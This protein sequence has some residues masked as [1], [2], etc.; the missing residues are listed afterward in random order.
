MV[1][2]TAIVGVISVFGSGFLIVAV[3]MW[4]EYRKNVLRSQE[5]LAAIEKGILP[6]AIQE[7]PDV[8]N[9]CR[10][11]RSRKYRGIVTL[12]VGIG[13]SVAL[14]INAGASA[15]V[16]GLFVAFIAIG[17]LIHGYLSYRDLPNDGSSAS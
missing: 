3:V 7:K 2:L 15:A 8:S 1:D 11:G 5:R 14:Y 17:Q 16:W 6:A 10:N 12:F 9:N 4:V 13:L